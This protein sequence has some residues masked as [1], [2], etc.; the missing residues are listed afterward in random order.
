[1]QQRFQIGRGLDIDMWKGGAWIS[2][3]PAYTDMFKGR[4]AFK[5]LSYKHQLIKSLNIAEI[6]LNLP[7]T[8]ENGFKICSGDGKIGSSC[9]FVCD[10]GYKMY[11]PSSVTCEL[12]E[13]GAKWTFEPP[14]CKTGKELGKNIMFISLIKISY[15][16]YSCLWPVA[17]CAWK[18]RL[19]MWWYRR[20]RQ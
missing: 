12:T 2:L 9:F 6:C 15:I 13:L 19:W 16:T 10:H 17:R 11:G 4:W 1:M 5:N 3:E 7:E 20:S 14:T 8:P 18:W